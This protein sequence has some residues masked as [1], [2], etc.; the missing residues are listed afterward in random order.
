MDDLKEKLKAV[1]KKIIIDINNH[2]ID[3]FLDICQLKHV[4][5][6]TAI[7]LPKSNSRRAFFI[8][9]GMVRGYIVMESGIEKNVF[10]RSTNKFTGDPFGLF[11]TEPSDYI[12]ETIGEVD[13]LVFDFDDFEDLALKNENIFKLHLF[14]YKEMI[15]TMANRIE[16]MVVLSPEQRFDKL[17]ETTPEL[18]E[19]VYLKDIANYLGITP[20]SLSRIIKRRQNKKT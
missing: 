14:S 9:K 4:K 16:S 17:V 18:Y 13:L 15:L 3:M 2:D 1:L 7:I 6:K 11:K 5:N 20:V 8:L 12:Y 19:T 10:I